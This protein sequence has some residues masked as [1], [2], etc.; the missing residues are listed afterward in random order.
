MAASGNGT[1][2]A[3]ARQ[4][5]YQARPKIMAMTE[6]KELAYGYFSQTLLPDYI[7][8]HGVDWNVVYDAR[9]HFDGA[10]HQS[11]HWLR[12]DRGRQLSAR[13]E[14]AAAAPVG[15]RA[16]TDHPA[17]AATAPTDGVLGRLCG[18]RP[19]TESSGA[20]RV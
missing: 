10:A 5:Y 12:D 15:L 11:A 17:R 2:P 16:S 6:D 1:L 9:G 19:A 20:L 7:E 4:I 13:A 14:G 8:E 18:V 3:M